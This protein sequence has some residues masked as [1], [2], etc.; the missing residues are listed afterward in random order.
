MAKN[1]KAAQQQTQDQAAQLPAMAMDAAVDG[2]PMPV[3][4]ASRPGADLMLE[5]C[6]LFGVNPDPKATVVHKIPGQRPLAAPELLSWRFVPSDGAEPDAVVIVTAGG[7]KLKLFRDPDYPMDP[8][9]EETLRRLLHAFT[10]TKD[11]IVD[12]PLPESLTLPKGAVDGVVRATEHLYPG[13]YLRK[14][15]EDAR[16]RAKTAAQAAAAAGGK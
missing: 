5:A 9:T 1:D 3:E 4:Y 2:F 7:T 14:Q 11:G 15:G 10:V 8:A 16:T 6:N 12:L 13:G